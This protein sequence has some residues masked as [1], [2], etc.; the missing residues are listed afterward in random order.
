MGGTRTRNATYLAQGSGRPN[1]FLEIVQGNSV[2]FKI[3]AIG[4]TAAAPERGCCRAT[5]WDFADEG[6]EF[7]LL[8]LHSALDE[9][10][11]ELIGRSG[12]ASHL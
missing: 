6:L 5:C 2:V 4:A 12:V 11:S 10:Y 1:F 8:G 7:V 3:C 9:C